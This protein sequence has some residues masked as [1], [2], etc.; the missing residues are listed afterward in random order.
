[1]MLHPS[2]EIPTS[3]LYMQIQA[4]YLQPDKSTGIVMT[5]LVLVHKYCTTVHDSSRQAAF[6]VRL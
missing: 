2:G 6:G 1:M 4:N 5:T 3:V